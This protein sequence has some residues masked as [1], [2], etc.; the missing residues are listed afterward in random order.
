LMGMLLTTVAVQMFL[1]GI[2]HYVLVQ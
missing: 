1:T 2:Q